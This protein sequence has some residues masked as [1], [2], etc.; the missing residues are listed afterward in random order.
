MQ[1]ESMDFDDDSLSHMDLHADTCTDGPD[2]ILIDGTVTKQVE[3]S[4]FTD[5]FGTSKDT[6][7][8]LCYC[9]QR[10]RNRKDL[11]HSIW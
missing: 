4:G 8:H 11:Y 6:G 10:S 9:I 2:M 3:V 5:D 1:F 7:W